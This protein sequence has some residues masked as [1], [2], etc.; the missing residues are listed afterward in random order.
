MLSLS[1]APIFIIAIMKA[2]IYISLTA[3]ILEEMLIYDG[4][5]SVQI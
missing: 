2:D 4:K 5:Y 3:W 1:V